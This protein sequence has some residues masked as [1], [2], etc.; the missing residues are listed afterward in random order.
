MKKN[1]KFEM[2]EAFR[3]KTGARKKKK[4]EQEKKKNRNDR[5]TTT[6]TSV[7]A[8]GTLQSER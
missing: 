6:C 2:S 1:P 4:K 5:M 3:F 8:G 7:H